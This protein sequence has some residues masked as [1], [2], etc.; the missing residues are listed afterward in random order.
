MK[1]YLG[2]DVGTYETKGVIVTGEGQ[3]VAQAA[4]P[5]QMIV[6]QPGWAEH[7][8]ERDWW[9]DFV[10]VTK[11]ML[12]ESGI[13][14]AS[15]AAIGASAI[16]PC[17]LP[18][19]KDGKPLMNAVLYGV[20]TRAT[21]EIAELNA[22]I[23]EDVI[24]G[25]CRN[26]L[27]TQAAGPKMLWLKRN[28]PE[29]YAKTYKFLNSTS[30]IN[31]RLTG[32]YAIDHYSAG[33]STPYY[34]PDRLGWSDELAP[35]TIPMEMMPDL[36][37][38]TDVIGHVTARAAAETGLDEGTPVIAGTIDAAAE[39]V[40]V[41]VTDPGQM[42]MMY[43][44][45]IFII[46]ITAEKVREPRLWY[47]PWLFEGQHAAM[48]GVSTAGTLTHWFR[49][50]TASDLSPADAIRV[51]NEEAM[52]SPPGAN[53]LVVLPYLSGALTPL[54]DAGA[55][56]LISGLDLTHT[57][58]DMF[59]ACLEGIAQATRHIIET[60]E[61]AGQPPREVFAVGGGTRSKVW[62]EAMSDSC[63]MVQRL[64]EKTWG[65][66]FGDAF[67]AALAVGD[68]KPGDMAVWNPVTAEIRPD[69][70]RREL[71]DSLY[72]RFRGLYQAVK[73]YR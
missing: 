19:D 27:T 67:L 6:P 10:F 35:G 54:F 14:P 24:L 23:G 68:A 57:R 5:H 38:T 36:H 46:E 44:S 45:T 15:I 25:A 9:G 47:S 48:A 56:G 73:P 43:G 41:G 66:S 70:A 62:A 52:A 60:Y 49:R 32:A 7:D 3:I 33:N 12:A 50:V 13:A 42:M 26:A 51:L 61:K 64:R 1:H 11:K 37:W 4:R 34:L 30:F 40:S 2:V 63:N 71:Y 28:R 16:G 59:R 53:G 69:P 29:V 20:D 8:A 22:L 55:K 39:A 58:G 21:A 72:A 31:F 65:A 17:V 18:V